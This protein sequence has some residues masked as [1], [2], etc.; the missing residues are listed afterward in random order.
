M[1]IPSKKWS[2]LKFA[3]LQFVT[4]DAL[5]KRRQARAAA[6]NPCCM[7]DPLALSAIRQLQRSPPMICVRSAFGAC[8]YLHFASGATLTTAVCLSTVDVCS[9]TPIMHNN[10]NTQCPWLTRGNPRAN[11]ESARDAQTSACHFASAVCKVFG[12]MCRVGL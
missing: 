10:V 12:C 8:N 2:P 3:T 6:I 1:E 4:Q 9:T 11:L 7:H 5:I